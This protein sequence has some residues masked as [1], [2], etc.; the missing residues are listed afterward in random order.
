MAGS[1]QLESSE[2]TVN[3]NDGK[4][5]YGYNQYK[6]T[7][8]NLSSSSSNSNIKYKIIPKKKSFSKKPLPPLKSKPLPPTNRYNIIN[9]GNRKYTG[10]NTQSQVIKSKTN[11]M[12][13]VKGRPIQSLFSN[14]YKDLLHE[15]FKTPDNEIKSEWK[16][17][18]DKV[19]ILYDDDVVALETFYDEQLRILDNMLAGVPPDEK[20]L[21]PNIVKT[22][23]YVDKET[24]PSS[25]INNAQ[26]LDH[27][28]SDNSK[29]LLK[30]KKKK[31]KKKAIDKHEIKT[32][33][34]AI[35]KHEIKIGLLGNSATGK[36]TLMLQYMKD[37]YDE[38]YIET[39]GTNYQEKYIQINNTKIAVSIMD[40][41][42]KED[43]LLPIVCDFAEVILFV[44]DLT[45][46]QS[47]LDI[48]T[49]Y[50]KAKEENNAFTSFLIGTKFDLFDEMV[51][52]YKQIIAEYAR[53]FSKKMRAPLLFCSSALSINIQTIFKLIVAK[54]L[55][56]ETEIEEAH[57]ATIEAIIE[58]KPFVGKV[59]TKKNKKNTN[60]IKRITYSEEVVKEL[61]HFGFGTYDQC[62]TAS[63]QT[64][65]FWNIN[66]VIDTLTG[67]NK[68][69]K[70]VAPVEEN[71]TYEDKS[72]PHILACNL[73]VD[74]NGCDRIN[75]IVANL[76]FYS[77]LDLAN[78]KS[79]HY[80]LSKY[81]NEQYKS[82]L[83]D[84][85][86]IV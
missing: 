51:D 75:R 22:A 56:I 16:Q 10:K 58:F 13:K 27:S 48:K 80:K 73:S 65:N 37:Y 12:N 39:V 34:Q 55:C 11:G 36:S 49:W 23:V 53:K 76:E 24:S 50:R 52:N 66:E 77:T 5:T 40:L 83:D 15:N 47:L 19:N 30:K 7:Q 81:F 85:I 25:L 28:K 78:N 44:F 84:Y 1:R 82:M 57:R 59:N 54:S 14:E 45:A 9:K 3:K 63:I 33:L 29:S 72:N 26:K 21:K 6:P 41:G 68:K 67:N 62:V 8:S 71:K 20:P 74:G 35:D 2:F 43:V 42:G 70:F 86:H 17:M 79:D 18:R 31:K 69:H 4:S 38:N 64:V 46:Q 60:D 32:G 61:V